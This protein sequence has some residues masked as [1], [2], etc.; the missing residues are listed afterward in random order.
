MQVAN[1]LRGVPWA[2]AAAGPLVTH[3]A[4]G[5]G[6]LSWAATLLAACQVALIGMV[7]LR[8]TRRGQAAWLLLAVPAFL[9]ASQALGH[10]SLLA[11]SGVSHALI[12]GGLLAFFAGTLRPGRTSL[13]TALASRLRGPLTPRMAAYTR[14]V[15][16]AWCAF[17]AFQLGA[18]ALLLLLAPAQAWSLFVNVLELPLVAG[19][20]LAELALRHLRFR[21]Y[22][23]VGIGETVRAFM[24]QRSAG[25]RG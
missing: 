1:V 21:S 6:R 11:V 12:Y 8:R 5:A 15:T 20:F 13:I 4:L 7:L 17:F 25:E 18:S 3:A 23:H 19:M 10:A 16:V 2:A 22:D 14:S 24:G 9:L